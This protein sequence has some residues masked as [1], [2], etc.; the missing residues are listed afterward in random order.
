MKIIDNLSNNITEKKA[1]IKFSLLIF[2]TEF[3]RGAYLNFIPLYSDNML[4]YSVAIVGAIICAYF[5]AETLSKIGVGWILDRFDNR[6]VLVTGLIMSLVSLYLLKFIHSPVL[7]ILDG[8]LNGLGF[9]P[10][11]LIVLGYIT[12]FPEEK[13]AL[14]MGIVYS[15]WLAGLGLGGVLVNFL[16]TKSYSF[17]LN[18]III[19]WVFC[20]LI[21]LLIKEG[22]KS[23]E[24]NE[25]TKSPISILKEFTNAKYLVP[26]MLLQT[27]SITILAPIIPIYLTNPDFIG[28][29]KNQ[30][31]IAL[32][33]LGIVTV[34]SMIVF[35]AYAKRVGVERLFIFG[36]LFTSVAIIGM[37][38]LESAIAVFIFG[39]VIGIS[40]SAVLPSWNV[41]MSNNIGKENKGVMWGG[42]S[43][44]EGLGRA[45]GSLAGGLISNRFNFH[46]SFNVSGIIIFVLSI[47]Y[48]IINNRGILKHNDTN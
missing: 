20:V 32:A 42:F 28:L 27:L 40:Y 34:I 6:V 19:L 45:L 14:S 21:G 7:L 31:G 4:K 2:L 13:R 46:F 26:G 15:A 1:V 8:A 44:I 43:T 39:L 16:I 18:I 29:S 41:I 24:R 11:W 38:N 23:K 35:G 33:V 17:A 25:V 22:I 37:G 9:A 36:L 30:Y 47:F 12:T 5:L 48:L 3:V 10:V